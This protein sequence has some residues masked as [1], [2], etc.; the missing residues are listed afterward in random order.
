MCKLVDCYSYGAIFWIGFLDILAANQDISVGL[1]L[2][3]S[4][5]CFISYLVSLWD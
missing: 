2:V 5:S 3:F 4:S 1:S